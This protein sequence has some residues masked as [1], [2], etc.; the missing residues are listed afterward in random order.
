LDSVIV[1]EDA[2]IQRLS[3][4]QSNS[5]LIL[6]E[7]IVVKIIR[8]VVAGR[9]PEAEMTGYLTDRGFKNIAPLLGEVIR[10]DEQDIP[11]TIMLAQGFV[12][13]QGD[14][15]S[16]TLD[17]GRRV[18]ADIAAGDDPAVVEDALAGY[19]TL[20]RAIGKRLAEMH[21][22]LASDTHLADFAPEPADDSVVDSWADG[23]VEQ[24][25]A[26]VGSLSRV[27]DYPDEGSRAFAS[28]F[29]QRA[30]FLSQQ[31]RRLAREAS[32][33]A[34]QTRVHGDFH[35]GQVLV[36][37][38]DATLIDFE[39]EPAK[40]MEQRRAKSSPLRDVAGMLRSFDYAAATTAAS[41]VPGSEQA[42]ERQVRLVEKFRR[43]AGLAFLD[44]YRQVLRAASR[45]WV[46]PQVEASLLDL[47]LLEKAAYEIRYEA[48]N[49]PAWIGIPLAGIARVTRHLVA[50]KEEH[51]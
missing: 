9:H 51:V 14:A 40:T 2:Q 31:A 24:I 49:R 22:I 35:L 44:A 28:D 19:L 32:G 29:V 8:K 4:E 46:E 11:H 34:L 48:A 21:E 47:F 20:A 6:D 10:F 23:V 50:E 12:G 3:A 41:R 30:A 36:T 1:P 26:A 7:Q 37:P 16:W 39:G 15:W 17:Y 5:S 45:P 27:R 13:N 38:G 43:A 33:H 42:T 18:S 25:E